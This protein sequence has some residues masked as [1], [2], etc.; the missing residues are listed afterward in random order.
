[1]PSCDSGGSAGL[2]YG[3]LFVWLGTMCV[4]TTMAELASMYDP[5]EISFQNKPD[6]P[7]GL[8]QLVVNITGSRN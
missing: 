6:H 3:Y 4:F 2:V 8:P 5:T 1:M 7:T